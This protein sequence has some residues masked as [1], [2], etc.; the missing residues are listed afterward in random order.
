MGSPARSDVAEAE[1]YDALPA[2]FDEAEL[3]EAIDYNEKVDDIHPLMEAMAFGEYIPDEER[4]SA[5]ARELSIPVAEP[6][7]LPQPVDATDDPSTLVPYQQNRFLQLSEFQLALGLFAHIFGLNRNQYAALREV[8]GLLRGGD[9]PRSA[10]PS[11]Q[12]LPNQLAT[13]KNQV[14]Q[15]F[16]LLDMRIAEVPLRLEKLPTERATRKLDEQARTGKAITADLHFI[17]PEALFVTFLASDVA[18]AMHTGLALFVDE[19][20]E[21]Y[22]SHSWASSVRTTSGEY[23]HVYGSDADTSGPVELDVIFPSDFVLYC[24]LEEACICQDASGNDPQNAHIGRVYGIG[25][26]HQTEFCTE[27]QGDIALQIQEAFRPASLRDPRMLPP[28][29]IN[30]MPGGQGEFELVI[31]LRPIFIP[32]TY[33]ISRAR[34]I[35]ACDYFWGEEHEDP[36]PA[37]AGKGKSV[38]TRARK[39]EY[40]KYSH[41]PEVP[42]RRYTVRRGFLDNK[43]IPLCYTHPIRAELKLEVY[44]RAL[45]ED[46]WAKFKVI[47]CPILIFIDG[48]GLYRN[49]Y[50]SLIGIYA[51]MASMTGVDRHRQANIFPITLSPHGSN[52]D[53]TIHALQSLGTLDR[54]VRKTINGESIIM[55]VPTLCYIGDMPQQDKNSGFRGPKA[56]KFCRFCVIGQQAVKSGQPNAVLDFDAITHGRYHRQLVE[57]R[58]QIDALP[59]VAAKKANGSQWGLSE[60][61]PKLADLSPALDLILSRPPDPAHSE[62]NGLSELMHCLLLDRILTAPAVKAY[63]RELRVWPFPPGW[64]DCSRRLTTSGVT[65]CLNTHDGRLLCLVCFDSGFDLAISIVCL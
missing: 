13:L 63:T 18:Q 60:D 40:P 23:A 31:S 57:M 61:R 41:R 3:Q 37:V 54:G 25:K 47:S 8:M 14:K 62:Y 56:L 33:L 39:K 50:R 28:H 44:T 59:T 65:P 2:G 1:E 29:P 64:E 5:R 51:I 55:C 11:I 17:D 7:P 4:P 53:D 46:G 43:I 32:E 21:L 58:Q 34:D 42:Y 35:I 26:D 27:Q 6:A 48:F 45:F 12:V 38:A 9:K 49:S 52:F 19:P 24:C 10:P 22:H 20:T 15:R 36:S 30:T 16:P